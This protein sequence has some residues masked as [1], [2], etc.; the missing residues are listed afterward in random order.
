MCVTLN[1]Y[2]AI[3]ICVITA[4]VSHLTAQPKPTGTQPAPTQATPT[5]TIDWSNKTTG[6]QA[7]IAP[8]TGV[9]TAQLTLTNANVILYSYSLDEKSYQ[10]P[11]N[12]AANLP[13]SG[14]TGNGGAQGTNSNPDCAAYQAALR[15]LW[16]N[17]PALFPKGGQSVELADSQAALNDPVVQQ[18][19]TAVLTNAACSD[20]QNPHTAIPA[21]LFDANAEV[22]GALRTYQR[23]NTQLA[24]AGTTVSFPY[25]IDSTHW[26]VFTLREHARY[27]NRISNASLSWRCGIDDVLTLSLGTMFTTLPY[28]TYVSQAVPSSSGTGTQNILVVNGNSNISPQGLA[29][30][31]Y[32]LYYAD[33]GPQLG[34]AFSTGPVF[35]FG[36]TPSV[37]NFGWFAGG[38]VALW[39]R[40][41]LS[42]GMHVGQF[43]D[44]PAGFQ[45]GSVIPANFGQLIPVT[46]WSARFAGGIS[47]QTKSFVQSSK[48]TPATPS[49]KSQTTNPATPSVKPQSTNP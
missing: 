27:N 13:G 25:Q 16:N 40:L 46:R 1:R 48:S 10:L 36:S 20:G 34:L 7:C 14:T 31:N 6:Q 15:Q 30:L 17:V 45:D 23:I 38:S 44:Y 11:G 18:A 43:A 28:R 22:P 21:D 33:A 29:L 39:R 41:F 26:Y 4:F 32:K 2:A 24:T 5:V 9:T 37:S 8:G 35:K 19:I 3:G 47:F 42:G 12:D 49:V